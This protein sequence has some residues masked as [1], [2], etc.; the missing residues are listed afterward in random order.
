MNGTFEFNVS[1][2]V[3]RN[4][5]VFEAV[6]ALGNEASSVHLVDLD[7][8]INGTVLH[9]VEGQEVE[10]RG[11]LVRVST[12]PDT[13]V[14]VRDR[15]EWTHTLNGSLDL[16]VELEPSNGTLLVVE[17]RDRAN[18][19]L[20]QV[21]S[22]IPVKPQEAADGPQWWPLAVVVAVGA[23]IVLA[24]MYIHQRVRG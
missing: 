18:N 17:F 21:V 5:L 2:V 10:V 14:R 11:V 9:P 16:W 13:W 24:V 4:V 20:E 23:I 12:D 15:T 8:L 22:I 1:L 19:T 7:N 3:G 6:D